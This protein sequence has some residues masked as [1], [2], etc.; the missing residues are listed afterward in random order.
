MVGGF[1]IQ[2]IKKMWPQDELSILPVIYFEN[3]MNLKPKLILE[4]FQ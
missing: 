1:I 2:E 3:V 4:H